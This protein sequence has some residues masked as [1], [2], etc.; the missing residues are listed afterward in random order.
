MKSVSRWPACSSS[1][2]RCGRD[3]EA[4][5]FYAN[6]ADGRYRI[7]GHAGAWKYDATV[8]PPA[9][10]GYLVASDSK[11]GW[12]AGARFLEMNFALEKGRIFRGRVIDADSNRPVVNAAVFFA[13]GR[14]TPILESAHGGESPVLAD[15]D[16][17]FTVTGLPGEGDLLVEATSE[18]IRTAFEP[19]GRNGAFFPHGRAHVSVPSKGEAAPV[20]IAVRK[21]IT[22]ESRVV[23]PDE[24]RVSTFA[25]YCPEMSGVANYRAKGSLE[26]HDGRFI[27][28]GAD[29]DRT[30][31][32]IL[33]SA[34]HQ[35]AAVVEIKPDPKRS[36][37]LEIRLQPT[38]RVH[39]RVVNPSAVAMSDGQVYAIDCARRTEKHESERHLD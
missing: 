39:G 24:N 20:D 29:P 4:G 37:P 1:S 28:P 16:G 36:Q 13:R 5:V 30:Y 14:T 21:G 9:D 34:R 27:F 19:G 3:R 6:G 2:C 17:R 10:S 23:G 12:P 8:Y 31:K 26:F 35:L 33:V 25:A 38:A 7:S 15:A 11:Q 32:V 18:Y 22:F